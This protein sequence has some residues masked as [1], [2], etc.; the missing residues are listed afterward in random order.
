MKSSVFLFVYRPVKKLR[1]A[2]LSMGRKQNEAEK[3]K[4]KE[5]K[6]NNNNN[7]NDNN[8]FNLF[9]RTWAKKQLYILK[10]ITASQA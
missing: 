2:P 3:K 10:C 9:Q 6:M 7:N 5:E 8:T 1:S 4:S